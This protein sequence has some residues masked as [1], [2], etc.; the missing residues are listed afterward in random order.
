MIHVLVRAMI[1][2]CMCVRT[3]AFVVCACVAVFVRVFGRLCVHACAL[4]WLCSFVCLGACAF[5]RVRLCGCA[6]VRG[7]NKSEGW[8]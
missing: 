6:H 8:L 3:C 7:Q 2:E 5:M 4:V 1:G